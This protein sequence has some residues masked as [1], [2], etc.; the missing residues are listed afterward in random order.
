MWVNCVRIGLELSYWQLV[1]QLSMG[2]YHMAA[3][4]ADGKLYTWGTYKDANGYMGFDG[5]GN[6]KQNTPKL[7]EAIKDKIVSV[8]SNENITYAL[9]ANGHVY[10]WGN[11]KYVQHELF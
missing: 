3:V 4:T 9:T 5:E 7:Y 2:E 1:L 6:Q 10:E 11:T 8:A